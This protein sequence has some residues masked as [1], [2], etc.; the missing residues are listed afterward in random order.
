MLIRIYATWPIACWL[1][2]RTTGVGIR[3][4]LS[5]GTPALIA[6]A[7]MAGCV[8]A[9]LQTLTNQPPLVKLGMGVAIGAVAYPLALAVVSPRARQIFVAAAASLIRRRQSNIIKGLRAEF[10]L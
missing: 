9:A 8:W 3:E 7:A 2:R 4:Q 1:V 10:G 6:A 5:T